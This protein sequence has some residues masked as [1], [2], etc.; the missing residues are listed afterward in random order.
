MFTFES[1]TKGSATLDL[2]LFLKSVL[3]GGSLKVCVGMAPGS[4][5]LSPGGLQKK[6]CYVGTYLNS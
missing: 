1:P 2:R 6:V 3:L 5:N 4:S